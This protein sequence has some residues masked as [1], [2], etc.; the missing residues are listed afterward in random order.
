MGEEYVAY[1]HMYSGIVDEPAG[2]YSNSW[3]NEPGRERETLYVFTYMWDPKKNE[4]N[5]QMKQK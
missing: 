1:E 4:A 2:C 3:W 5:E